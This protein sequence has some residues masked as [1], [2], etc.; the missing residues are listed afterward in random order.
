MS[1]DKQPATGA[2]APKDPVPAKDPKAK[3]NNYS[4]DF[5]PK[6][7]PKPETDADIDTQGG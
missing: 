5:K 4:P 2:D 6:P 7:E 1:T 3:E